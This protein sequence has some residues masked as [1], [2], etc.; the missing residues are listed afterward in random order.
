MRETCARVLAVALM[1]GAIATVVGTAALVRTP[2]E[3]GGPISAPPWALQRSVRLLAQPAPRRHRI[4]ARLVTTRTIKARARPEPVQPS[5][6]VVRRRPARQPVRRREL[7]AT[8]PAPTPTPAPAPV[9]EPA[10]APEEP[11]AAPPAAPSAETDQLE[12]EDEGHG[13]GHGHDRGHGHADGR[14]EQDD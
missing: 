7:A 5:L 4:V 9:S 11:A 8:T 10:A 1:T 13:P 3:A 2:N 12:G 6:A 14:D